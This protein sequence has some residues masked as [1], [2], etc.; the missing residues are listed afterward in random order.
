MA[1]TETPPPNGGAST[2]ETE[3]ALYHSNPSKKRQK[4]IFSML[5]RHAKTGKTALPPKTPPQN[6]YLDFVK[7]MGDRDDRID[8]LR[9]KLAAKKLKEK[10][11]KTLKKELKK[12]GTA[13]QT[14]SD[15][16]FILSRHYSRY[17]FDK[18]GDN[19][20]FE[21]DFEAD[22]DAMETDESSTEDLIALKLEKMRD[23]AAKYVVAQWHFKER[24][25]KMFEAAKIANMLHRDYLRL[26]Y[27]S[28]SKIKASPIPRV[29]IDK[30][31][32]DDFQELKKKLEDL[33]AAK[34]KADSDIVGKSP[35]KD[36]ELFDIQKKASDVLSLERQKAQEWSNNN[37]AL[38]HETD[39][40]PSHYRFIDDGES[41]PHPGG[42]VPDVTA[43]IS[44]MNR[45]GTNLKIIIRSPIQMA[46]T[47]YLSAPIESPEHVAAYRGHLLAYNVA[48]GTFKLVSLSEQVMWTRDELSEE[49]HNAGK[50]KSRRL[51]RCK[52]KKFE[53]G[54]RLASAIRNNRRIGDCMILVA[55]EHGEETWEIRSD[56][57]A[58]RG[59]DRADWEIYRFAKD[60]D[61]GTIPPVSTFTKPKPKPK[62]QE[63][64]IAPVAPRRKKK[65]KKSRPDPNDGY[66]D[67]DDDDDDSDDDDSDNSDDSDDDDDD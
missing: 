25:D 32:P 55:W 7:K 21:T 67:D 51:H 61:D 37:F 58:F 40:D 42:P 14:Y 62:T 39:D 27:R 8:Q 13:A 65:A 60:N 30:S 33:A 43:T 45:Y 38:F 16:H 53:K 63:L 49:I 54:K 29:M 3:I 50:P 56:W 1:S 20:E 26:A 12:A 9:Q 28:S 4:Q 36:K 66:S 52:E 44:Q 6:A 34:L 48:P 22:P 41:A 15:D 57:Q 46:V 31:A 23:Q 5:K 2:V 47:P 19:D 18:S 10:H 11:R 64:A 17:K 35:S 59:K 24:K